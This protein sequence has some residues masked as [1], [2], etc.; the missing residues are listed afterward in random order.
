MPIDT[1][2]NKYQEVPISGGQVRITYIENGWDGSPSVR[3]QIR[4]ETGHLRQGP[5]IPI[6]SI[7]GV[8]GAVVNLLSGQNQ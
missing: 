2:N 4:D 1:S 7:G 5:E 6:T 8:V 3:I